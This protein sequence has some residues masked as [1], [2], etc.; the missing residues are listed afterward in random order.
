[1]AAPT[2]YDLNLPDAMDDGAQVEVRSLFGNPFK[3]VFKAVNPAR[4][5]LP[6]NSRLLASPFRK[7]RLKS[8]VMGR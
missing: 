8:Q 5:V 7:K 4:P 6:S 3:G 2:H 1:V